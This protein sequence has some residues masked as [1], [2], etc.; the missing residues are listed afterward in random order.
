MNTAKFWKY[1]FTFNLAIKV[2]A[3]IIGYLIFH[4][5]GAVYSFWAFSVGFW[6]IDPFTTYFIMYRDE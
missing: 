6:V 4:L 3:W 2:P 1:Y 5:M